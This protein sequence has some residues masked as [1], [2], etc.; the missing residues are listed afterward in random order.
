MFPSL[1]KLLREH[2]SN[3]KKRVNA[4]QWLIRQ[5]TD[6]KYL[7]KVQITY[8]RFACKLQD[9]D[10]NASSFKLLGDALTAQ[11]VIVDDNPN[12]IVEF[13]PKQ[14]Q[15]FKKHEQKI[16]VLIKEVL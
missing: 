10:N 14:E 7:G 3:R 1:N 16:T 11:Q 12:V 9:H 2:W 15:V 13:I 5:Q 6:V 8:T 4:L